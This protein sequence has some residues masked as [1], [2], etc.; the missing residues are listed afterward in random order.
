MIA[1]EEE[2]AYLFMNLS[3]NI[4]KDLHT[5]NYDIETLIIE[6]ENKKSKNILN[7]I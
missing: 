4:C 2:S 3:Y 1:M 5:N 7:V 6:T